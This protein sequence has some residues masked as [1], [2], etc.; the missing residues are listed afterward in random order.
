VGALPSPLDFDGALLLCAAPPL[1]PQP[2]AEREIEERELST[3]MRAAQRGDRAAYAQLVRKIMPLLQRVLRIRHGFFQAADRDDLMQDVLLSLHRAMAT[4]DSQREFVPWL[5]AIMRNKV[6]DR[7][8]RFARST[9]NE[10]LVDD[11]AEIGA[12]E[13]SSSCVERYG[14]PEALRQ[15]ISRLSPRHRKAIELFKLRELTSKEAATLMGT[16]PGALRVSVHRAINS[17]RAS[18]GDAERVA[19]WDDRISGS[20]PSHSPRLS[21]RNPNDTLKQTA[22]SPS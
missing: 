22:S 9:A 16:T 5:M 12:A 8:R 7:A 1:R 4:Y 3:L 19:A 14:D 10:I 6:V 20:A 13:P 2:S 18:L 17:L 15:A 11:W 21:G